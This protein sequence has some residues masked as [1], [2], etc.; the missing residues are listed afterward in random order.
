MTDVVVTTT[1]AL[2]GIR[3]AHR[4]QSVASSS[5]AK[6]ARRA[7]FLGLSGLA[8]GLAGALSM[9]A[10]VSLKVG[11]PFGTPAA[12]YLSVVGCAALVRGGLFV[13]SRP[14]AHRRYHGY[15]DEIVDAV[16]QA[17]M[18]SLAIVVFT[19]FWRDGMRN[20]DFS[21]SRTVFAF[22]WLLSALLLSFVASGAKLLLGRLRRAGH[23]SENV[24]VMGSSETAIAMVA[25]MDAHPETGYH[26]VGV[27]D[28]CRPDEAAAIEEVRRLA[29]TVRVDEVVISSPRLSRKDFDR[30]LSIPELARTRVVAA[31]HLFGLPPTKAR[32]APVGDFPLLALSH[33]PLPGARRTFKRA[34]DILLAGTALLVTTPVMVAAAIAI[35]LNSPGPI[36]FRQERVGMDGRRFRVLKFRTMLA[37]SDS[38][39]HREFVA[40]QFAGE[41][42]ASKLPDD[43]RI[44]A[45]GAFL[46]RTSIDE[47]P[48]L[49]TVLF[50]HMSVV[51][52]RPALDYE[53]DLYQDWQRRRLDVRP[54]LTGLWQVSGR[55]KLSFQEMHR[56]D[57]QYIE[58]WTPLEDL[59]IVLRT[60]PALLRRDAEADKPRGE[61]K[62]R[63]QA[64][65]QR[66]RRVRMFGVGI[67]A[68]TMAET[69]DRVET[70]IEAG[71]RYQHVCINAAKAVTVADDPEFAGIIRSCE[72]VSADG[73]AIVWAA[74]VLGQRLPERVTGI[75]LYDELLDRA[76]EKGWRVFFLGARREV[77]ERVVAIE[78]E[79]RPT[80]TVAGFRDGY[81]SDDEA[82]DVVAEIAATR[83][84]LLFVAMPSPRKEAFLATHFDALGS[85]F[86]MGVGGTFDVVSGKITRAPRWMRKTGLEWA[87]RLLQEPRRMFKRYLVGNSRFI[88]I[89]VTE[90]CRRTWFRYFSSGGPLLWD[91]SEM[92]RRTASN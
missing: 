36:L 75:D 14:E 60:I 89:V 68:L 13:W 7:A 45:V 79:R 57:V 55:S 74:R 65:R 26:V 41:G 17:G 29:G 1:H 53:V 77:V 31:P 6:L 81:F 69:V 46:R 23:D 72:L 83:P 21:Y 86:V 16:K 92:D 43:P 40:K 48:Q 32:L 58:T 88:W 2:S 63:V 12:P 71:G 28:D 51:G 27:I 73:Q 42:T 78:T 39:P 18:G 15:F 70:L 44:T 52:P 47:L 24:V 64:P 85:R 54:G 33:E 5:R 20:H 25:A 11:S 35:R 90:R 61:R 87:H 4:T 19:F 8:A 62:P 91:Q 56:L 76:A 82:P 22:D 59:R 80:L 37:D 66:A 84:D 3:T 49:L 34:L 30:L 67:D 38:G 50:G 9:F 10:L